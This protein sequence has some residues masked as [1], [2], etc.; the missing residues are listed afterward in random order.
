MRGEVTGFRV[1]L[2]RASG[3]GMAVS[4]SVDARPDAI[5]K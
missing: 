2:R 1:S 5:F 4:M 3:E